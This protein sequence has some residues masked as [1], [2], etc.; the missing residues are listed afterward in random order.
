MPNTTRKVRLSKKYQRTRRTGGKLPLIRTGSINPIYPH[1]IHSIIKRTQSLPMTFNEHYDEFDL[2]NALHH[3]NEKK[4]TILASTLVDA[5]IDPE[6][7]KIK[8]FSEDMSFR[9][10]LIVMCITIWRSNRNRLSYNTLLKTASHKCVKNHLYTRIAK[11]IDLYTAAPQFDDDRYLIYTVNLFNLD[12]MIPIENTD[13]NNNIKKNM[14]LSLIYTEFK[15][16]AETLAQGFVTV[17]DWFLNNHSNVG[18]SLIGRLL[19]ECGVSKNTSNS[20]R[21]KLVRE[22]YGI[23][24]DA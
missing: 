23:E 22:L 9:T 17:N 20:D 11:I 6:L 24:P 14:T 21:K 12:W 10:Y 8:V 5:A 1:N 3:N 13:S 15:S 7:Q 4:L 18:K 16:L 2:L 19:E